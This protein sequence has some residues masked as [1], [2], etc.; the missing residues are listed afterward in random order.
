MND[1]ENG[2]RECHSKG[3]IS[4]LAVILSIADPCQNGTI[5]DGRGLLEAN[6]VLV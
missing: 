3:Y 6:T 2:L 5:K 1:N 4:F